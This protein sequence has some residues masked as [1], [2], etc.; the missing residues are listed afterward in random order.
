[1]SDKPS[2]A[3][4]YRN[5]AVKLVKATCLYLATKLGDLMDEIVIVGGLAPSLIVEQDPL[6]AG[7][8]RHVGTM[9]LDLGLTLALLDHERYRTLAERMRRSGFAPDVNDAGRVTRQRWVFE[10]TRKIT[11]DFLI[12][13][14]LPDDRGGRIR[15]IEF[16]FAAVIVPGLHLAFEDRLHIQVSGAT[17]TGERASRKLWVCGP[18]A[19]IILKALA[20]RGRG[21]NKDAYDLYYMLRNFGTG[22]IDVLKHMRPLSKDQICRD[23]IQILREDFLP[24]D[25]L[26]PRRVAEFLTG[27]ADETIQ[28][29]VVGFVARLLQGL[30][31]EEW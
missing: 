11:I 19:F 30:G 3:A 16:D 23:A 9:D 28:T 27:G 15:N 4:G 13:P 10:A 8:D 2:T 24:F 22:T 18:G 1:M 12:P 20:F 21:E 29:D 31:S 17:I 6:P 25:G 7:V 14:S 26:G 5:E